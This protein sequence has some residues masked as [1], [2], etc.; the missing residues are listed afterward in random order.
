MPVGHEGYIDGTSTYFERTS[1]RNDSLLEELIKLI[2]TNGLFHKEI[3]QGI[4]TELIPSEL[5]PE[6]KKIYTYSILDV[7]ESMVAD[8][9]NLNPESILKILNYIKVVLFKNNHELDIYC[10][11]LGNCITQ[12]VTS[13]IFSYSEIREL[14]T[15]RNYLSFKDIR[16]QL[17]NYIA[18]QYS[19]ERIVM[20][21]GTV[22]YNNIDIDF[23]EFINFIKKRHNY[24]I[25]TKK[26][27]VGLDQVF[28]S[29]FEEFYT[30]F[31]SGLELNTQNIF[32]TNLP[33]NQEKTLR[34]TIHALSTINNLI[35]KVSKDI[36]VLLNSFGDRINIG[37]DGEI[38]YKEID[39]ESN[40]FQEG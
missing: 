9:D 7:L 23:T 39:D 32:I 25:R 2:K 18:S 21:E 3:Q 22:N 33:P 16:H 14:I 15:W 10:T 26:R 5:P 27:G 37:D 11:L 30:Q 38:I 36:Y 24:F 28:Q 17:S 34:Y 4:P 35:A 6:R 1:Y 31:S 13:L 40:Y 19:S 8:R 29:V 20:S 12:E